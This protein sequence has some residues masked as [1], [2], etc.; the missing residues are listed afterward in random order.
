MADFDVETR[1]ARRPSER[2]AVVDYVVR[3]Q[4]GAIETEWLEW[5]IGVDLTT[6]AGRGL[7]GRY[8]LGFANRN[9]DRA[10]QHAE[11]AA[12]LLLGAEPG[13]VNAM[14]EHDPA[15]LEDWISPYVGPDVAWNPFYVDAGVDELALLIQV[16]A[17]RQGEPMRPLRQGYQD[18]DGKHVPKGRIFIRK[19]GKTVEA[20]A[21]DIDMLSQRGTAASDVSAELALAVEFDGNLVTLPAHWLGDESCRAHV[22]R[23]AHRLLDGAPDAGD[24]RPHFSAE[25]RSPAEFHAE[26]VTYVEAIKTNWHNVVATAAAEA[27][28]VTGVFVIRNDTDENYDDV[29]LEVGFQGVASRYLFFDADDA[30]GLFVPP[31]PPMEWNAPLVMRGGLRGVIRDAQRPD[32]PPNR[33]EV[34]GEDGV[35]LHFAPLLV[36][37]KSRHRLA[38]L[39]FI[40]PPRF[41]ETSLVAHWRATSRSTRGD[42]EGELEIPVVSGDDAPWANDLTIDAE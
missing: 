3:A 29:H 40:L 19:R 4:P 9:P 15:E 22:N 6:P 25:T 12:Y 28:F 5:K 31:D 20:D 8:V 39:A 17:P 32:I 11:G 34:L 1:A 42:L 35:L 36:R 7:V 30:R 13:N 16:E 23:E 37:P 38:P 41:A 26:L 24:P 10:A 18:R 2:L 21:D 33:I 27:C 14:P